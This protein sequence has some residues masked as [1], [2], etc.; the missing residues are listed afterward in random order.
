MPDRNRKSFFI[1]YPFQLIQ[2]PAHGFDRVH[3]I[4]EHIPVRI[5]QP[6]LRRHVRQ[7]N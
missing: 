2:I 6:R 7:T 1:G 5:S 3:I 4:E